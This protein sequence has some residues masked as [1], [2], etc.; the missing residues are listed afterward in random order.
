MDG[1]SVKVVDPKTRENCLRGYTFV[2]DSTDRV[3]FEILLS[4]IKLYFSIIADIT[5]IWL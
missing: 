2:L 4:F 1:L 5:L 3:M